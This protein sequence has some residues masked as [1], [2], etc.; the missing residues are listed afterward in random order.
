MGFADGLVAAVQGSGV[1]ATTVVPG[2]MRTGSHVMAEFVGE[3]SEEFAWFSLGASLPLLSIDA[4]R[5]ARQIV[6]RVL[7]GRARVTLT[8]LA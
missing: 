3:P 6:S 5:A 4:D 7:A 8:P 1:T 2:L